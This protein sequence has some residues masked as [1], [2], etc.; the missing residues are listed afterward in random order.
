MEIA[1]IGAEIVEC[2]R[3]ARKINE[4]GELFLARV[5]TPAE[6]RW[7]RDSKNTTERFAAIWAGK[8]A[9]LKALG[10]A[11]V[12]ELTWTD[13]EICAGGKDKASVQLH[14]AI[15]DRAEKQ[16]VRDILIATAHC[17]SYATA[18]AIAIK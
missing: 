3:I 4:H 5:F 16:K 7:C 2:T 9:V 1:G 10:I 8:E 12:K 11:S 6:M 17:R 14:G 13:L 15:K 18:Y